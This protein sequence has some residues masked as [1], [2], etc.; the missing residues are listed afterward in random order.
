MSAPDRAGL[1]VRRSLQLA[2]PDLGARE[3]ELVLQVLRSGVLGLGPM[4]AAFEQAFAGFCGTRYAAAVSSGTTGLHLA[5]RLAGLGL[6]DEV[7]TSPISFVASANSVLYERAT[8]VFADVDPETFCLD[9]DAVEA[10]IT[11]RTRALMPV[12]VFGYPSDMTRLNAIARRHGLAVIEDAAEAVGS[13]REGR[14]VGCDGNPAIFAFYPNKQMTTGEGGIVTTDD[15]ATYR[16][17]K[18]L[19]NQGRSDSG[20]W[21]EH[22]RLG[23]NYRMDE[24]SA[25]VGLAQVE[26]LDEILAGRAAVAARY[27]A[28]LDGLEGVTPPLPDRAGDLRSWFVYVVRVDEGHDRNAVMARLQVAGVACKPY[29]PA[30][31]LQPFY[32]SL[33]HREGECPRAEAI[34]RCTLALPF[35]TRLVADDQEYVVERLADALRAV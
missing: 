26:R 17:L 15:E 3:E 6:G 23:Y 27:A 14:H 31:H 10:A 13:R 5:V 11:P 7:V 22:D 21:L 18:S 32:R 20:D 30:V 25:A 8:P 24:L 35:H 34:A 2:R 12:H 9:P 29:L 1:P 16:G 4:L 28:L 33:G 19:L